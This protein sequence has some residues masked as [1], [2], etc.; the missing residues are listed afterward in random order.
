MKI[1]LTTKCS[2][3]LAIIGEMRSRVPACG[4]DSRYAS[5][6]IDREEATGFVER[7]ELI[8]AGRFIVPSQHASGA[9]PEFGYGSHRATPHHAA[10]GQVRAVSA[11]IADNGRMTGRSAH[12]RSALVASPRQPNRATMV[13]SATFNASDR[14]R[15]KQRR[16]DTERRETEARGVGLRRR[17]RL[18]DRCAGGGNR[19]ARH[20]TQQRARVVCRARSVFRCR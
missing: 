9:L 17:L 15:R 11:R 6:I 16:Q 10:C 3:A 19:P 1:P 5:F 8:V 20:P 12:D 13:R 7:L 14:T 18:Y 2:A 4:T